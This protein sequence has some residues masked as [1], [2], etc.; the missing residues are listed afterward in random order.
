LKF[1]LSLSLASAFFSVFLFL[2]FSVYGVLYVLLFFPFS[3][4]LF[5][6]FFALG[7]PSD[8]KG[9]QLDEHAGKVAYT[10]QAKV[11]MTFHGQVKLLPTEWFE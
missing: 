6:S 1:L 11:W 3:F 10:A 2:C 9:L 8:G 7:L 4:F 5:L